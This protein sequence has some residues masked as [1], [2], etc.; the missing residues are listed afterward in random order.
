ML[1]QTIERKCSYKGLQGLSKPTSLTNYCLQV[2]TNGLNFSILR[3]LSILK[4]LSDLDNVVRMR[5]VF[6]CEAQSVFGPNANDRFFNL[7]VYSV[8]EL[9]DCTLK[10]VIA[11]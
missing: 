9:A 3:E 2:G 7:E 8:M 10:N 1:S 11:Q 5:D 6:M 4:N